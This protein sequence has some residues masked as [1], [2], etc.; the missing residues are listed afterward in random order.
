MVN[1]C[2]MNVFG[3][4]VPCDL[5][6]ALLFIIHFQVLVA[7]ASDGSSEMASTIILRWLKGGLH[8]AGVKCSKLP[9]LL[10]KGSQCYSVL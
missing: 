7:W 1:C 4:L 3:T 8:N 5:E 2:F 9:H 10:P 6:F